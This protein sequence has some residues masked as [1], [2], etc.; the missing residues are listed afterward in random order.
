MIHGH[1]SPLLSPQFAILSRAC[2]PHLQ[3][4][5]SED[6]YLSGTFGST[7]WD[8]EQS[9]A[10][11]HSQMDVRSLPLKLVLDKWPIHGTKNYLVSRDNAK[12]QCN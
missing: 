7:H 12:W 6:C 8:A 4:V 9:K 2:P 11:S 3:L 5:G 1:L 10:L